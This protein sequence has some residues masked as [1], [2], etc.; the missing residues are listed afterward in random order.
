MNNSQLVLDIKFVNMP[1]VV[2]LALE[3]NDPEFPKQWNM[4]RIRA[5]GKGTTAWDISTGIN[6]VVICIL[7]TGCD[8][9]HPDLQNQYTTPGI[10]LGTMIPDGS[11]TGP[12]D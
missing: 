1:L 8:L 2:P 9:T 6:N 7:D 3:P 10:N 12:I 5:G 11:P 4:I